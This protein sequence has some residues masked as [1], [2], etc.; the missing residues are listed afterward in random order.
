MRETYDGKSTIMEQNNQIQCF[1]GPTPQ[2][3]IPKV[4]CTP[5]AVLF[6]ICSSAAIAQFSAYTSVGAG[7]HQNPLYN[8]E[9]ISDQ[10][11]QAFLDLSY[12]N[13]DDSSNLGLH[14]VGGLAVFNNLQ[15]RNFYEHSLLVSYNS[16]FASQPTPSTADS[17]TTDSE[18]ES[19]QDEKESSD[20]QSPPS[21]SDSTDNFIGLSGKIAARHDKTIFRD[22]D[23]QS[24]EITANYRFRLGA[25]SYARVTNTFAARSYSYVSELSNLNNVATG[26]IGWWPDSSFAYGAIISGGTKYYTSSLYDTT[27]FETQRG[28]SQNAPGKGK[29]GGKQLGG[30]A[31]DILVVPQ[32]NGTVQFTV[33]F[34]LRKDWSAN[35]S[36]LTSLLYRWM[37]R[38]AVRY[39]AQR[40]NTSLMTQDIYNDFFSYQGP[41]MKLQ[42]VTPLLFNTRLSLLAG[43]QYRRYEAP[44]LTLAGMET[45]ER[46]SDLHSAA[47]LTLSRFFALSGDFGFD[48]TWTT[49]LAR[50]QSND[51]Y[52][53]FSTFAVTATLGISF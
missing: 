46:R 7:F 26:E 15:D 50:N 44:A 17:D 13:G 43:C 37:P 53:D 49:E 22:F 42:T 4:R 28:F 11:R 6:T 36:F 47:E 23:N 31:K 3:R 32:S 51:D 41:E 10:L 21:F 45:G 48:L 52:N 19:A 33:G 29:T 39:L 35:T 18:D 20:A 27:R 1:P 30:P 12:N 34:F 9:K 5:F 38:P 16:R 8:Y 14:Y 24:G 40:S 25:H 2:N